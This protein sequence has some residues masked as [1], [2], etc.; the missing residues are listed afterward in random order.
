MGVG[1]LLSKYSRSAES[2]ADLN[3]ARMLAAAGYNPLEMAR[4]FDAVLEP[5][6]QVHTLEDALV[7]GIVEAAR[8]L[9]EHEPLQYLLANEPDRVLPSPSAPYRGLDRV[10][11]IATA[12]TVPHVRPYLPDDATAAA[13][14]EWVVRQFFSYVLVPSPGLDLTDERAVRPFVR[15]YLLPALHALPTPQEH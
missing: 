15:T 5:L 13:G 2:D 7:V 3:G 12:F 10:Y 6:A 11:E 8:F 4:F 1:A 9:H 14:A